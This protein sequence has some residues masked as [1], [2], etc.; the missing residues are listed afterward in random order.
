M[1][2]EKRRNGTFYLKE[3][4]YNP[5]TKRPQNKSV[6]LG[7]NAIQ[8]KEKLSL[9]TDDPVLLEQIP[10]MQRYEMELERAIKELKKLNGFQTEGVNGVIND[11]LHELLQA[12]QFISTAQAGFV[13]ITAECPGC[14]F[15]RANHC[16]H[17][18]Q[19][20][21]LGVKQSGER[22]QSRCMAK[23]TGAGETVKG[24]IRLPCDFRDR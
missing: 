11:V 19:N 21:R 14:R 9:L 6:Y 4:V 22:K 7:A 20:F 18:K 13:A 1:Y 10:D 15:N 12:K 2:V 3:S 5:K 23:E 17:F 24:T 8:A 16:Q